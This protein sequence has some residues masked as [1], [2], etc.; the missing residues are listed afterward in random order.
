MQSLR[1]P[2]QNPTVF[3]LPG[4]ESTPVHHN[5]NDD[6]GTLAAPQLT[7]LVQDSGRNSRRTQN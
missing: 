5:Y 2:V 4:L 1:Q 7:V 3:Y 6:D